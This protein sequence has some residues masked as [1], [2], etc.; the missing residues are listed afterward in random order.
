MVITTLKTVERFRRTMESVQIQ[1]VLV[2]W[3]ILGVPN[4]V[5]GVDHPAL[6]VMLNASLDLSAEEAISVEEDDYKAH[7]LKRGKLLNKSNSD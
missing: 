1:W 4:V 3:W 7:F 6:G 5:H 2:L